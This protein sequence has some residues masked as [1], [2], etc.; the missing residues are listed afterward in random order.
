M[1]T[2]NPKDEGKS[3]ARLLLE[4]LWQLLVL[5]VPVFLVTILPPWLAL[6]VLLA[7]AASMWLAVKLGSPDSAKF[8][9]R[10]MSGAAFGLGFSLGR[11]LPGYWG[12]FAAMFAMAGGLALVATW[13]RR[14]GLVK[15]E[16]TPSSAGSN[17][18]WGGDEPTV[19]PEGKPIRVFNHGEIAMGGPT[20]CDYLFSDGVL[21]QGVGS[22]ARFSTDGHYFAAPMPSRG[23]WKLMIFDRTARRVHYCDNDQFWELDEF[24]EQGISGRVSPLVD[25]SAR[26]IA[27]EDL[28]KAAEAVDLI[29]IGDLWLEPGQ[30]QERM[31]RK[32][33]VYPAPLGDLIVEGQL[34]IPAN[35]RELPDPTWPLRYPD[36]R[37]SV[38]GVA[39]SMLIQADSPLIWHPDGSR[40]A[41]I[42]HSDA[43][44]SGGYWLFSVKE[45]WRALP[46]AWIKSDNEP[47]LNWRTPLEL[48]DQHLWVDAYLDCPRPDHGRYGYALHSIHSNTETEIGHTPRGRV[49]V[50]DLPLTRVRLALSLTGDL[51]R[52]SSRVESQPLKNQQRAWL[53]WQHDN[54]EGVGAYLCRI[55]DW[56]LPGLWLLD[57]RVS[58]CGGFLALLPFAEP[59]AVSGH[60]VVVD[61]HARALLQSAPLLVARLLDF[62]ER[63]LT[64]AAIR[65]RLGQDHHSIALHRFDEPAPE[66]ANAAQ[67]CQYRED[68]RLFYQSVD[69]QVEPGHLQQL[70]PWRMA[71]RPQAA[72]ADGDFVQVSPGNQDAAWL[73]G[74]E[75]EY[76]DGWLRPQV[77][78]LD[79]HLLTA[80]GCALQGL[81]P[82]LVWSPAGRY[83]ALTSFLRGG[84]SR[85]EEQDTWQLLLLDVKE[86]SLRY[87]PEPLNARPEFLGFDRDS[88]RLK[89]YEK[90]WEPEDQ[91]DPSRTVTLN[92]DTLLALPVVPLVQAGGVWLQHT[93]TDRAPLWQALDTSALAPWRHN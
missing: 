68:S 30:W 52:G 25:N 27:L 60:V 51:Q 6:L 80:S 41:C 87:Y 58:D 37:L 70:P 85:A 46:D 38:N 67:F 50:G 24:N 86:H 3:L 10:L 57:H 74:S 64:V 63:R 56:Q 29:A 16:P 72:I 77:L 88:I 33:V 76:A 17:S 34:F 28:L 75:T 55:G 82:S 83:L 19:T 45:G 11:A 32:H 18:A 21:L 78:R 84:Y 49:Q 59:P 92:L 73:F 23:S 13:E 54:A 36:Y 53:Q 69:F 26:Q 14:L 71:E 66:A 79:G 15:P 5:L 12:I 61:L 8:I 89:L 39:S 20:Y 9:A 1:T 44:D 40:F 62:R 43:P 65:G 2:P 7:C 4:L 31:A 93:Q 42:A 91:P 47:S 48:D 90:D 22:S 35:L 81:A